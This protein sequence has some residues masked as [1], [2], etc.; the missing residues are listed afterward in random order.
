MSKVTV[1]EDSPG[2]ALMKALEAPALDPIVLALANEHL[3]GKDFEQL[4]AEF[5]VNTD[6]VVAVLN[7]K[8]VKSYIDTVYMNQ[9]YMNRNKRLSLINTVI[10]QQVQEAME[11]GGKLSKKD[12]LDWIKLLDTMEHN[13][14]PKEKGPEVAIQINN[15][16]KLMKDLLGE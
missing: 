5:S 9:G 14:K 3:A 10:E 13:T 16:T 2:N 4:S 8:D 1:Y 6:V 12:L 15:Y 7:R 11:S